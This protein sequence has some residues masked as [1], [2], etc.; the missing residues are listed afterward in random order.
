MSTIETRVVFRLAPRQV[1]VSVRICLGGFPTKND[2]RSRWRFFGRRWRFSL[3][4]LTL[5]LQ[6]AG[7]TW[8]NPGSL[9][10]QNDGNRRNDKNDII[11]RYSL[12]KCCFYNQNWEGIFLGTGHCS[13]IFFFLESCFFQM[14][15]DQNLNNDNFENTLL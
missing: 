4:H 2:R 3:R 14:D 13:G 12:K 6:L 1:D 10:N 9:G 7:L 11:H 8:R 15:A 5:S